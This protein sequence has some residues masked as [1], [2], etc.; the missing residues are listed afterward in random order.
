MKK[1]YRS[2]E[3]KTF[4]GI[5]GGLGEYYSLDPV[6]IRLLF[7]LAMFAT[8]IIPLILGYFVASFIVPKKKEKKHK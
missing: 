4:L 1:L 2:K 8:G 3:N 7:V 5:L 6:L